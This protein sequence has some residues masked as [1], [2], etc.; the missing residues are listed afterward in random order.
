MSKKTQIE[1]QSFNISE[2]LAIT[3]QMNIYRIVQEIL[4]NAIKH[5]DASRIVLQC[6]QNEN[7]FY[8][9]TEDNGKGFDVR[10][11]NDAEGIGLR[12]I[13]NRVAY[14]KGKIDI[15]SKPDEGTSI[16]IE[17]CV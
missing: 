9:T 2:N 10:K 3:E 7:V 14:M 11:I 13:K 8:I 17:L 12:N 5:A 15:C 4:S 6:S 1:F 16:N